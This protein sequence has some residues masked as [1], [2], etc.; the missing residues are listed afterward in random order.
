MNDSTKP[1]S[2]VVRIDESES[3]LQR[4]RL[5][6]K[7]KHTY[8]YDTGGQL[9]G[10]VDTV[11]KLYTYDDEGQLTGK[12]TTAHA[13]DN[14]H[15]LIQRGNDTFVYDGVGN[16]I[17]A[18]RSG[19]E[20]QY[21]YDAAG[22]LLAQANATGGITRYCIYGVGLTA[23][24]VGGNHYVYHFDGTGHTVALTDKDNVVTH[25]YAYTPYG[26]VVGEQEPPGFKQPFTYAAQVGIFTES[27][28]L[29]YMRAR[30]YDAEVG[31]FIS[32]DPA[33]F[34]DGPN[35]YA[36]VGG[37]PV[38]AVDPT[39]LCPW[40]IAAAVGAGVDV[41]GQLYRNDWDWRQVD[42]VEVGVAGLT[43]AVL[44]GAGAALA[45]VFQVGAKAAA[46]VIAGAV[47]GAV[48]RASYSIAPEMDGPTGRISLPLGNLFPSKESGLSLDNSFG[49][50]AGSTTTTGK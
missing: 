31:R 1:L 27:D 34:I 7:S 5:N 16:R 13:F 36:Y 21:I 24:Q 26:K 50:S 10:T 9:T 30:Y 12:G 39:G 4:N 48:V 49:V 14:A 44:P 15:R 43:A 17:K 6:S 47:T 29:Y 37:N 33:G 11:E 46:P 25:K 41:V 23:M 40:C 28:N 32:E 45:E 20:T 2:K 3:N 8:T 19:V 35:L 18:I 38:N 22:N 42:L